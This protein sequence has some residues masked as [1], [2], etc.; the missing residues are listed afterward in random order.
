MGTAVSLDTFSTFHCKTHVLFLSSTG[1]A[2]HF[3]EICFQVSHTARI[4]R[5]IQLLASPDSLTQMSKEPQ[6]AN[7]VV[8]KVALSPALKLAAAKAPAEVSMDSVGEVQLPEDIVE[9][10]GSALKLPSLASCA[11]TE[12]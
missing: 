11:T 8:V 9:L 10:T 12:I 3:V 4:Q 5:W 6:R 1:L 7:P 2:Y